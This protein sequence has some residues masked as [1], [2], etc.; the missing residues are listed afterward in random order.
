MDGPGR[1]AAEMTDPPPDGPRYAAMGNAVTVSVAQ[2][3]GER[4]MAWERAHAEGTS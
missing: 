3:I 2:W 1:T 4:I